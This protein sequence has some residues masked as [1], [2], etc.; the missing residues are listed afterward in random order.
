MRPN[1][2]NKKILR[3]LEYLDDDVISGVLG[4]IKPKKSGI[5]NR[6][7]RRNA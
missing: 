2:S 4:K 6:L 5:N 3:G 1:K 7:A